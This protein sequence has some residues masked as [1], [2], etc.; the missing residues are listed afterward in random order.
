[1]ENNNGRTRFIFATIFLD[2]LGI[3]LLIPVM[4]EVIRRF[5]AD[6]EF[7]SRY[8]GYFIAVYALMQF[9][10]SPVLGALSDRY[11][12][13]PVLLL[14]LL[15]AGLDYIL[16][17]FAPHLWILFLGRLVSGLTGASMTVASSYMAD[18]STDSNRS[19][20]FG[21]I[22]AGWG[23][24]FIVGPALGGLLAGHGDA[25]P[26]L[27]A[28]ALNLLNF[29]W[30]YFVLP[31]SLSIEKRRLIQWSK[32]NPFASLWK[33]LRP[34]PIS[35]Y[36]WVFFF[37]FLAGNSHPSVWTLF[38]EYK[39]NW[40]PTDVGLSLSFTGLVIAFSQGYLT[41]VLIP[42]IGEAKSIFLGLLFYILGF[43][44]Y[45]VATQGWMMYAIT[46]LY[47][48]SGVSSP[49][50][51][52]VVTRQIPANEQGEFQGSLIS[53]GSLASIIAPLMYTSLFSHFSGP[54]AVVDYP[55]IVYPVAA[56]ICVVSFLLLLKKRREI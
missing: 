23:L 46:L 50:L 51:Q 3:G 16:M 19:A 55:G 28:A 6:P 47:A 40:T 31:E 41:R 48:F 5:G 24:G 17:A 42:K 33:V 29:A 37:L 43:I 45:G 44:L 39:F 10:A 11:G 13:R 20:N 21:L 34:S 32:L 25:A 38:T 22:G 7:V 2:A 56:G 26:F 53:I 54:E 18:I 9:L 27:G 52:S 4:P 1:M 15:C 12:R 14:S 36:I 49:A 35:L 30:G 8:F